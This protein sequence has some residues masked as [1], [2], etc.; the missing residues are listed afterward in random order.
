MFVCRKDK[1]KKKSGEGRFKRQFFINRRRKKAGTNQRQN[2]EEVDE[3]VTE[4]KQLMDTKVVD[5]KSVENAKN[6]DSVSMANH[7]GTD[8][9]VAKSGKVNFCK[10]HY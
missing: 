6:E 3:H 10:L 5:V 2:D 4:A 8:E 9:D 7:V 1:N